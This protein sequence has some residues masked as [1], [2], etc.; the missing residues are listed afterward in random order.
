[1]CFSRNWNSHWL[2]KSVNRIIYSY[3][4]ILIWALCLYVAMILS[5]QYF[6]VSIIN[7][8]MPCFNY[9]IGML[10]TIVFTNFF[11]W[12]ASNYSLQMTFVC[13]YHC[14]TKASSSFSYGVGLTKHGCLDLLKGSLQVIYLK[15]LYKFSS[16]LVE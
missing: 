7:S 16:S 3:I 1:M 4:F 10:V 5:C 2:F 15:K 14:I 9:K 13:G 11:S 6:Y 12:L 8:S